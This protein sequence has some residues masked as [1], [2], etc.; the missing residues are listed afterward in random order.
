MAKKVIISENQL[1]MLKEYICESDNHETMVRRVVAELDLNY[2]PSQ[3]TYK[4]GGEYHEESMVLN[5]VNQE[6]MTAKSLSDYLKY[7]HKLGEEFLQQIINDWF[8]GNL[9]DSDSLS[10]NISIS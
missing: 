10:K 6:L 7:K 9:K 1:K 3:G 2:E 5:K 8:K 4:K